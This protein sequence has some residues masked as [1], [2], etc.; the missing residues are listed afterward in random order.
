VL[1]LD[2][3]LPPSL[4]DQL[5]EAGCDTIAISADPALRGSP[6]AEVLEIAYAQGRVLVT[7]NIR[8][9]APLSTEWTAAGR[10][11]AGILLVSSKTFPM[12]RD[13]TGRIAA[14]L[15]ARHGATHWPAP[16]QVE[17]LR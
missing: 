1:L 2:E 3:M 16:G 14:A 15:L 9:F 4:A 11:H 17:F 7:D 6:D 13:R 5:N 10:A 12:T 8:D